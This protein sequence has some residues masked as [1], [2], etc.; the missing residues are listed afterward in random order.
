[1]TKYLHTISGSV[2]VGSLGLILPHE[3]LFTDLRGPLA[4]TYAQADPD[5]VASVVEPY[6]TAAHTAGVTAIVD[7]STVGV[8]RNLAV[9]QH[10]SACTPIHIIAPTG[11]Y[12]EAFTPPFLRDVS[13]DFLA[14]LWTQELLSGIDG[15]HIRAGFIKLAVS[16]DGPTALE[17]RNLK[18][19]ARASAASGA[20]IACHAIGGE[21]ALKVVDILEDENLDL[22]RFIWVH[23]QAEDN[24][25]IQ[26][27]V[28]QRGAF[29]EIDSIGGTWQTQ[30]QLIENVL[31]IIEAGCDDKLLL[32]HDAGWYN[33]AHQDGIPDE[34][35]RGYTDL[36]TNFLP[37]LRKRRLREGQ[38]NRITI[39]N[40]YRAFAF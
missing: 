8:G 6:L 7:C 27:E 1:M 18:G 10:L 38:V 19:A 5:E 34:G 21:V 15:T 36:I 2:A 25:Q 39:E 22:A 17:I 28:A 29:L 24:L 35:F 37:A 31:G 40:P 4:P 12:K 3:H 14:T 32:S 16:D 9:L 11:I 20:V 33:P 26:L 30:A 23:A 13:A